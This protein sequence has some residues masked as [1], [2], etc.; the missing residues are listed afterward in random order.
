MR[1]L[2]IAL[3]ELKTGWMPEYGNYPGFGFT[4]N[5][6]EQVIGAANRNNPDVLVG[7]EFLF[8]DCTKPYT[9]HQ[10]EEAIRKM[11]G[12]I[13]NRDMLVI[14][15][16]FIW[17][18]DGKLFNSA[19]IITGGRLAGEYFKK[20]PWTDE[21]VAARHGCDFM[22]GHEDGNIFRW[23]GMNIGLEICMDHEKGILSARKTPVD[24][25]VITACGETIE[26]E[27]VAARDRGYVVLSD[28]WEMKTRVALNRRGMLHD[29]EPCG[30]S[31]NAK[32]YEVPL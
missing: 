2:K 28:G 19:P 12:G 22:P 26:K 3:L 14:P 18:R 6:L 31:D 4:G 13:A 17:H 32:I 21:K 27:K 10:K 20:K 9:E 15:G 16:T 7:P 24:I 29:I 8:Y 11:I 1:I 23:E 5:A 30:R 25:H